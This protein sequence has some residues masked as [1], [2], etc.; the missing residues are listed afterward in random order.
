MRFRL[1]LAPTL[2]LLVVGPPLAALAA[3][4]AHYPTAWSAWAETTR[5]VQLIRH[6]LI[7][8][9]GTLALALP[10]GVVSAWL[11]FRSDLP[12]RAWFRRLVVLVL[13]IPLPLLVS[14]WQATLGRGGWFALRF[15]ESAAQNPTPGRIPWKPWAVGLPAAIWVHALA[16]MPWVIWLAGQGFRWVEPHLEEDALT[17]G[18]P[19]RTLFRVSLPRALPAIGVAALWVGIQTAGEITVTDMMQVR[20]FAEEVYNE[21]ARP[22]PSADPDTHD[23]LARTIVLSIPPTLAAMLLMAWALPRWDRTSPPLTMAPDHV[24][25]FA[26]WRVALGGVSR[27][28]RRDAAV[29]RHSDRQPV[30]AHGAV[31][32]GGCLVDPDRLGSTRESV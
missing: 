13:F 4:L 30:L 16:A 20:T 27:G 15:W 24:R 1:V 32:A 7:L 5:L 14:A 11:I 23:A 6:T 3:E 10:L 28:E 2:W 17:T 25:T 29:A 9:A 22:D 31:A 12:G 19:W 21:F 26:L 8:I 18:G